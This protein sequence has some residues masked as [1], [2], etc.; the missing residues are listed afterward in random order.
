MTTRI[1]ESHKF[2][3]DVYHIWIL[4]ETEV[5]EVRYAYS[6]IN[7]HIA[8]EMM[9][10]NALIYFIALNNEKRMETNGNQPHQ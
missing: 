2:L 5:V 1:D 8:S 4:R 6:T 3:L 10:L 7:A 9:Q